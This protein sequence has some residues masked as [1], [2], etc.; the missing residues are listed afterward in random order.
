M[1]AG[2]S[3]GYLLPDVELERR[4]VAHVW[5]SDHHIIAEKPGL[6]YQGTKSGHGRALP[7][8]FCS[9]AHGCRRTRGGGAVEQE[10]A[11]LQHQP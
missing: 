6:N 11:M 3:V 2:G 8:R 1:R 9:W 10:E 4:Q 5:Y 7:C